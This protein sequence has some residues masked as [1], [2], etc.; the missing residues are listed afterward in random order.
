MNDATLEKITAD[1]AHESVGQ[2]FGRIFS[3]T[4]LQFAIDLRFYESKFLFVSCEPSAPRL[5]FI[6]RK[7]KELEKQ[8]K[9]TPPFVLFLRKRLSNA[10]IEKVE[11]FENERILRFVLQARNEL[12]HAEVYS[13]IVQLT[14]RSANLFL[15]DQNDLILDSLKDN[16]GEGQQIADKYSPPIRPKPQNKTAESVFPQ[17]DFKTLSDALDF[18]YQNIEAEKVFQAKAKSAESKIKQEIKKTRKTHRKIKKRFGKSRRRGQLET[19]RRF[20]SG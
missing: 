18:H 2:K 9:N 1:I 16:S 6:R 8:S 20:D 14:G 15:L 7:L 10:V 11:K 19:L 4:K 13:L 5:Y 17:N 3:L 12:G